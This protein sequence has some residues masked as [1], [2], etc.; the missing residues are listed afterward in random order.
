MQ[1]QQLIEIEDQTWCPASL[2]DAATD[3]LQ[4]VLRISN[5]YA[6]I[7]PRLQAALERC[8]TD[9]I[10]DMASGGSGPWPR[11]LPALVLARPNLRLRLTDKFPNQ[12]AYAQLERQFPQRV[13]GVTASIDATAVPPDTHGFRTMFTAFHHFPPD[14]ARAVLADAVRQRAGIGIFEATQRTPAN[15]IAMLFTPIFVWITTPA[16]PPFR[17]SRFFWTYIVPLLPILVVWDGVVSCL[18]TYTP[19]E[20]R[21]LVASVPEADS[22]LW[23]I[24]EEPVAGQPIPV[25]YLIGTPA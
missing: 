8:A 4:F 17:W 22:Y 20:L 15:I 3:Y 2:R 9:T 16:A 6:A 10:V 11:L 25:T 23:E 24:G 14:A 18:R 1:R 19:D 5:P 21:D 12:R 13:K 7:L